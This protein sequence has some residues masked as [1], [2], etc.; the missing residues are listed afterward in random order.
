[1]NDAAGYIGKHVIATD[2]D[3]G[4]IEDVLHGEDGTP[5]FLVIRDRGVFAG[6]VV[7]PLDHVT[8]D[9]G[10]VHVAK[11]RAQVHAGERY[12]ASRHGAGAGLFSA[13][14]SQYDSGDTPVVAP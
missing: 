5:R 7:L 4:V 2:G 6:D 11:S 12:D 14:A 8:M 3:S 1:M 10:T 13:S 9:G